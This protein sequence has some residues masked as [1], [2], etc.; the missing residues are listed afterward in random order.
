M[1]APNAS[2]VQGVPLISDKASIA[3]LIQCSLVAGG[4]GS[5]EEQDARTG[6][7]KQLVSDLIEI[8]MTDWSK[9]RTE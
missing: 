9:K 2:E 5:S 3:R 7:T 4:I 6:R 1:A 8:C